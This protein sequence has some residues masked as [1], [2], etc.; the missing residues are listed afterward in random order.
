M[1]CEG[2]S[3]RPNRNIPLRGPLL[4]L[5]LS[6]VSKHVA[7]AETAGADLVRLVGGIP[8]VALAR[9]ARLQHRL[10]RAAA[11]E[12]AATFAIGAGQPSAIERNPVAASGAG[13]AGNQHVS[14]PRN[15]FVGS[16]AAPAAG[17]SN[18]GA[19]APAPLGRR[20]PRFVPEN[21]RIIWLTAGV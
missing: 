20:S 2:S 21:Q 8:A 13:G 9:R 12:A 19:D 16:V 5:R 7:E 14:T 6:C 18:R 11:R 10:D 15:P 4:R 1:G 3:S 17:H